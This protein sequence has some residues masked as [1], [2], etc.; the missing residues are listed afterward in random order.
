[1]FNEIHLDNNL[2]IVYNRLSHLKSVSLG[3]W[4]GSGSRNETADNNGISHFIEHMV[5]KGTK[6][7]TSKDIASEIDNIGGQ[8]NAFTSKDCTCFYTSTLDSDIDIAVDVL[9]DMLFNSL[10]DVEHIEKEKLVVFEEISMYEDD[11]EELVNDLLTEGVWSD[12]PLGYPILGTRKSVANITR[13]T[14]FEYMA[15]HYIPDNCVISVVGNF[16]KEYLIDLL[17]GKFGSWKPRNYCRFF[18]EQPKFKSH[19]IYKEK[20]TEQTH[21]CLGFRGFPMKDRR[22]YALMILNNIIGGS[23]S[24]RLFQ[25]I[26]EESGLAYSVYSFPS[27]FRDCGMFTIY[28]ATNPASAQK[29][30]SEICREIEKF[31]KHGISEAEFIRSKNQLKGNYIIGLDST[32]AQMVSMGKS[33]VITGVVKTAADILNDIESV[34][35]DEIMETARWVFDGRY[36]GIAVLGGTPLSEPCPDQYI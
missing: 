33:K 10:F 24:S 8:I 14:I 11:P 12:G 16:E 36:M 7:R 19:Y 18:P 25:K 5:F 15:D 3:V 4:I 30:I 31:L 2:T 34:T 26:R 21:L 22:N 1:M 13:E 29:V 9:S 17:Q 35:P 28:A 32:T 20:G 27:T 6:N 23:I